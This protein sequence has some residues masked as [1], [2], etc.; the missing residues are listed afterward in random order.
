MKEF[1]WVEI[2]KTRVVVGCWIDAR[3][4]TVDEMDRILKNKKVSMET[5]LLKDWYI[6]YR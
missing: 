5:G 4:F 2:R 1:R 6:E 3:Y